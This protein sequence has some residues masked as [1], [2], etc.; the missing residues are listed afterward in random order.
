MNII[1]TDQFEQ[2]T[3][4]QR[5]N[6][7]G[8]SGIGKTSFAKRW[9]D[10][11]SIS[12]PCD[13]IEMDALIH[14]PGW[15]ER[16]PEEYA[17]LAEARFK[18]SNCFVFDGKY[19]KL[20]HLKYQYC[21]AVVYLDY[22]AFVNA[23]RAL[24]RAVKRAFD[25]QELWPGTECRESFSRTFLNRDSVLFKQMKAYRKNKHYFRYVLQDEIPVHIPI[26]HLTHP[27]QAD[28]LLSY[29][30]KQI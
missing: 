11:K 8:N 29:V 27:S 25:Y 28:L 24:T 7:M 22:S 2:F 19:R 1:S 12:Q 17:P 23:K 13:H 26:F 9:A 20:N 6:I 30:S 18:A 3:K 10:I 21:Q 4:Y 15:V 16:T 5:I 14:L